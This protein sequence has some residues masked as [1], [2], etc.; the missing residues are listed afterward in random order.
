M[1]VSK[2]PEQSVAD[3]IFELLDTLEKPVVVCFLEGDTARKC[4]EGVYLCDNLL[5]A[6]RT[7]VKLAGVAQDAGR[8]EARAARLKEEIA[9]ARGLL[10]PG[11]KSV[12]GLF[13]GG[14]LCAEA[15]FVLRGRLGKIRSNVSHRDGEKIDGKEACRGSVLLDLGDDEFTN[16]RP[17]PMIEPSLRNDKIAEQGDDPEVG[18][19][20]LDFELGYGSHGDPAGETV[21]AIREA[22]ARARAQGRELAV[23]GYICGTA[24]DKQDFAGQRAALLA[25][26]VILAESNVEAA[27]TAA[28]ILL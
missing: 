19:I 6:A 24:A 20:L 13:C 12:R 18:V 11:Q 5:D 22:R 7:A 2:P 28:D 3:K 15:L 1:L 9:G 8:E 10:Q 17:H 14:T 26:G 27:Q 4:R 21:P 25:E 16:G 23:V